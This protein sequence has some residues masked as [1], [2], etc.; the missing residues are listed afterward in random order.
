MH[1]VL[2]IFGCITNYPKAQW[3]QTRIVII[4]HSFCGSGIQEY[5]SWIVLAKV[6]PEVAVKM[7][8]ESGVI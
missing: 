6:F 7:L 3:L 1:V 8:V 2:V 5:L 4:S